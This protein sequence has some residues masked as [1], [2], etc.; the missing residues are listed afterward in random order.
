MS[1][2]VEHACPQCGA[3]LE[4][5]Q[6]HRLLR[7]NYCTVQSFLV[8]TGPL[9]FILPRREPDPYTLYAPYHHFK[10]T[11]YSCLDSRIEHRLADISTRGVKLAFL[12]ASLG[13]RPQAM[14]MRFATP[15][16][17]GTFLKSTMKKEHILKR[18]AKNL[19]IRDENILHQ[20]FIGEVLDIIFLPLSIREEQIIDGIID[21]PI[22][23]IQENAT[24]FADAEIDNYTW[25]P[26]FLSALCPQCG[27]NLV[28]EPESVVLVCTN[29]N[30][31]WQAANNNFSA[32]QIKITPSANRNALYI[33][34]W[35]FKV[36]A[37]GLKLDSFADFIRIT[38]QPLVIRPEWEELPL[39]FIIP[40]F[41]VRPNDFLRLGSQMTISNRHTLPTDD[42]VSNKNLHPATLLHN[43]AA[44]SLTTIL[45][46]STVSGTNVFPYLPEIKF[47]IIEHSL[48]YLPFEKTSHELQQIHMGITIN[49]RVLDYGRSL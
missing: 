29:C 31:A 34:F 23:Q 1:L 5:E 16:L 46:N 36:T 24:P 28:G 14:K 26:V 27:W 32:V 19:Y 20:A 9:H 49:Q 13:L 15:E 30:T 44:R 43:D 25:K 39:H 10:G 22:A 8:N 45:A 47:E 11:I 48:H 18:A 37:R 6:T 40:A 42:D 7:C 4:M 35:D 12:P 41:K 33:P 2:H 17:P 21:R 38:N 3:P